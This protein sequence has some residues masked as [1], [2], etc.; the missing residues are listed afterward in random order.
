M[1][2]VREDELQPSIGIAES[3][4][5]AENPPYMMVYKPAEF[6]FFDGCSLPESRKPE[7]TAD[8]TSEADIATMRDREG[9]QSTRLPEPVQRIV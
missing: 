6:A 4:L 5:V 9:L 7:P 1:S 8:S 3:R 2:G